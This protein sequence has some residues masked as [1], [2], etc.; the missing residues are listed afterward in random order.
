MLKQIKRANNSVTRFFNKIIYKIWFEKNK[1]NAIKIILFFI[2]IIYDLIV[3]IKIQHKTQNV[4]RYVLCVGNITVGGSGKTPCA[5][6]ICRALLNLGLK[7]AFVSRGY[8]PG[9]KPIE[10]VLQLKDSTSYTAEDVGDEVLL[11]A[12]VADTYISKNRHAAARMAEDNGAQVIIMDDGMQNNS[13]YKDMQIAIFD[14]AYGIGNGLLL[15]AGPLRE[16]FS[17]RVKY[18]DYIIIVHG[19]ME[20]YITRKIQPALNALMLKYNVSNKVIHAVVTVENAEYFNGK[21]YIGLAGIGHP[22]KFFNTARGIGVSLLECH[23]FPDHYEYTAQDLKVIY[24]SAKKN[25]CNILTTRKDFQ[26]IPVEFH[27][28][29]QVLDITVQFNMEDIVSNIIQAIK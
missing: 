28:M 29:T 8:M 22:D 25:N 27:E 18:L 2:S 26:R 23:S 24:A 3:H 5:I 19:T 20:S 10:S 13:L 9:R 11:L 17:Y 7:V 1:L 6:A 4:K 16:R 15:P 14:S 21:T 12:E